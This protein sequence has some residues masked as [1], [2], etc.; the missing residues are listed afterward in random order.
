MKRRKRKISST[1]PFQGDGFLAQAELDYHDYDLLDH[2]DIE[3][4]L[5]DFVEDNYVKCNSKL[6]VITGKGDVIRPTVQK[7]LKQNKYVETFK[8]AGYF[9][10]QGGAFEVELKKNI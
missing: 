1:H 7:A 9:N 4:A 8:P 2:Y 10:G 3:K 5:E 6:L